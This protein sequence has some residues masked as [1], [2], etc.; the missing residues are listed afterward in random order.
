ML[1]VK[2]MSSDAI[3]SELNGQVN[4][5]EHDDTSMITINRSDGKIHDLKSVFEHVGMTNIVAE[6]LASERTNQS[7]PTKSN[8]N[9]NNG[10]SRRNSKDDHN[11]KI[12]ISRSD[13]L[14]HDIIHFF[15]SKSESSPEKFTHKASLNG[16][17]TDY[18]HNNNKFSTATELSLNPKVVRIVH[19]SNTH[20]FLIK[21]KKTTY[22]PHGNILVHSGDFSNNGTNEEFS[23]FDAWLGSVKDLYPYRVVVLGG[24][25]AKQFGSNFEV[26]RKKLSNATHV[27]CH[28][29]VT[30]LGLR[31]YG[32]PWYWGHRANMTLRPGAQ[33][34]NRYDDI[35][36]GIQVLIT[37]A[38]AFQRL[39]AL[40]PSS[41]RATKEH[42]GSIELLEAIR[43]LRPCL[44][45]HGHVHEA[46][47]VLLAEGHYPLTLNSCMADKDKRVLYACP[48]VVKA[49]KIFE[50]SPIDT[51]HIA[52]NNVVVASS[53]F[54][55]KNTNVP[56]TGNSNFWHFQLDSLES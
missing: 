9:N 18:H 27:L 46:R 11:P 21:G 51:N 12:S 28:S 39:D 15:K 10:T 20:N 42:W 52:Q 47:G 50:S 41:N 56:L 2:T 3:K 7:S 43:R 45:L 22:L 16:V 17:S 6:R 4:R 54:S 48:H 36:E 40:V 24:R 14:R 35:P 44:H 19:M 55:G 32:I 13:G 1:K 53:S 30:I 26:M 5:S 37:H 34:V 23:Q 29:E 8:N 31:F 33:N 49:E 25:D 38:P